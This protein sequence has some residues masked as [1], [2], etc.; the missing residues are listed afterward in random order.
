[1]L[2]LERIATAAWIRRCEKIT[3][4]E[5]VAQ[6]LNE[7]KPHIPVVDGLAADAELRALFAD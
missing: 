6:R 5:A 1:V 7:L 3:E 2:E 4:S